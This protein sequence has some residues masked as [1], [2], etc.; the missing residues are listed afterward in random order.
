MAFSLKDLYVKLLCPG[1]N[2]TASTV[3]ARNINCVTTGIAVNFYES[4]Q[5]QERDKV[6]TRSSSSA[7]PNLM[8][9]WD[10]NIKDLYHFVVIFPNCLAVSV[11][12]GGLI[13]CL[14]GVNGSFFDGRCG[15][16]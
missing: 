7:I 9:V 8:S 11:D 13:A 2:Y 5:R 3:I 10:L 12:V 16:V 1:H 4:R 14:A 15:N 6:T